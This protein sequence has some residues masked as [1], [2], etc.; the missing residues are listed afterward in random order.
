MRAY[1]CSNGWSQDGQAA[2]KLVNLFPAVT[3]LKLS[4]SVHFVRNG[5]ET[6]DFRPLKEVMQTLG[7]WGLTQGKVVV[8]SLPV[9]SDEND[10]Y[11]SGHLFDPALNIDSD[12]VVTVL[13]GMKEW[14]GLS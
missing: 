13:E 8:G 9:R 10:Y 1:H 12:V 4:L 7:E 3:E 6:V 2:I 14:R 11:Y 5:D